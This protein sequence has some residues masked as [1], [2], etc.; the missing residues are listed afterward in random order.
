MKEFSYKKALEAGEFP[1]EIKAY[2][3]EIWTPIIASYNKWL[4]GQKIRYN[5]VHDANK[6]FMESRGMKLPP[7]FTDFIDWYAELC[8]QE[9]ADPMTRKIQGYDL[10]DWHRDRVMQRSKKALKRK[11]YSTRAGGICLIFAHRDG[12]IPDDIWISDALEVYAKDVFGLVSGHKTRRAAKNWEN[13]LSKAEKDFPKD[14]KL[15][16]ELYQKFF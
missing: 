4:E 15:A 9:G 5:N 2:L 10:E 16:K 11:D 14:Y 3:K 8:E 12:K 13:F 7:E 6:A 1:P